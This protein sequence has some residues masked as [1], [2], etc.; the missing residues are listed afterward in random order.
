MIIFYSQDY[1]SKYFRSQYDL[2]S[3]DGSDIS[4][5]QRDQLMTERSA[6][7]EMN[8]RQ[9]HLSDARRANRAMYLDTFQLCRY[10]CVAPMISDMACKCFCI[11]IPK[12]LCLNFPCP[13]C[14][15]LIRQLKSWELYPTGFY[16][17]CQMPRFHFQR[18]Y[19]FWRY[20]W[21]SINFFFV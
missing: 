3:A 13:S 5:W 8:L 7:R 6:D 1:L 17:N 15:I 11:W 4:W 19:G 2:S 12:F 9:S 16:P 10:M 21:D 20:S 18:I 14:R